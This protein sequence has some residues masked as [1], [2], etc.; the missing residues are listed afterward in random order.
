M[1]RKIWSIM[2][3]WCVPEDWSTSLGEIWPFNFQEI[4]KSSFPTCHMDLIRMNKRN[5][6]SGKA[7]KKLLL[8]K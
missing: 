1:I 6:M 7:R 5:S 4:S 2:N 8:T 3:N